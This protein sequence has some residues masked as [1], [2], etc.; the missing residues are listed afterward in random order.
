MLLLV[1]SF[2][3]LKIQRTAETKMTPAPKLSTQQLTALMQSI[4]KWTLG[5]DQTCIKKS[6]AFKDF[7]QAWGW[8]SRVA[9]VAEKADH[10]P[11]WTNVYNNVDVELSTHDSQG[12]TEKDFTLAT[13]M[14]NLA[15]ETLT[16]L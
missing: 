12:V 4:S 1:S 6:F 7:S 15:Q 10:H 11:K 8:M 16:K 2:T 14:D 5:R 13:A 9:L 3:A